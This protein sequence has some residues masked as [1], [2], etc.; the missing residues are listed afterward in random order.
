M[1]RMWEIRE[2]YAPKKHSRSMDYDE[3]AYEEGF[4]AGYEKAMEELRGRYSRR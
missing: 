1:N 2:G 3:D 4:E